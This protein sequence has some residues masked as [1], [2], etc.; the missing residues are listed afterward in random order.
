[1][2]LKHC[3]KHY[4]NVVLRKTLNSKLLLYLSSLAVVARFCTIFLHPISPMILAISSVSPFWTLVWIFVCGRTDVCGTV[5]ARFLAI[6]LHPL[7]PV[8][9]AVSSFSPCSTSC[10]CFL[11]LAGAAGAT[12]KSKQ[13]GMVLSQVI[14]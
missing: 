10:W 9:F 5:T 14:F 7:F 1:M 11:I 4:N 13:K 12:Y 8:V 6:V 3:T 2:A